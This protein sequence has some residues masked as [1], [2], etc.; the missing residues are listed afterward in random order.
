MRAAAVG[1]KASAP[2]A[3]SSADRRSIQIRRMLHP[4][5]AFPSRRPASAAGGHI[6]RAA[7]GQR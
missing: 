4:I 1:F 7:F 6:V 2:A 5:E 3:R